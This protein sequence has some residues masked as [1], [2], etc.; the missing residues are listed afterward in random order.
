MDHEAVAASTALLDFITQ[1]PTAFHTVATMRRS[2]DE[3]GFT[4]LP[5]QAEWNIEPGGAYYT[6]RNSSSLVAFKIGLEVFPHTMSFRIAAAHSDAP[7]FKLK[8][9]PV[10]EGPDGYLRLNVEA[11][12]G[13]IDASWFDRPLT[14]AGRVMVSGNGGVESRLVYIDRDL[15]VI[16]H[17]AIHM[18]AS[19]NTGFAPNRRIDL[20]PL[21]SA[22]VLSTADFDR[23]IAEAAGA[24]A[25]Q[26]VAREL[27]LVS[28][29]PGSLWGQAGEFVSSAR[30]D[31]LQCAFA[32]HKAFCSAENESAINVLA[33]FDNEEVGSNTKQGAL[34][35][36]LSDVLARVND[37]LDGSKENLYQ[38]IA[39]SFLVSCDNAH[40]VHPNHPELADEGNRVLLNRGIVVKE[41]A[42]Q[43]YTTDAFSRAVFEEICARAQL[44]VQRFAN[45]SDKRGGSTLGNLSNMQVSMHAVDVGLPQL[46]MHS[47]WETAGAADTAWAIKALEAFWRIPLALDGADRATIGTL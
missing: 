3:A 42:N 4:Y 29:T 43:K 27:F 37:K 26:V 36:L 22:G 2:L 5:E 16:P 41:A 21:F 17:V 31:D 45:R 6:V 40:A 9:N 25:D 18:D 39:R 1:C 30:L 32:A 34:S 24:R 46:A 47:A 8:A 44:P 28:R 19:V 33:V 20:C 10:L 13:T 15:L 7:A 12:G 11:Y 14:I 23:M 35:T 38:A